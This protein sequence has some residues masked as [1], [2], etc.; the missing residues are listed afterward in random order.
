VTIDRGK[1]RNRSAFLYVVSFDK[2]IKVFN[3][4]LLAR[5][6]EY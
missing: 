5:V 1:Y 2:Q 3:E 6:R 4:K